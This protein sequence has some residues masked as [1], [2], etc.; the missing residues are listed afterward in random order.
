MIEYE[1]I[2]SK[3]YNQ[4]IT[5]NF[6]DHMYNYFKQ[7]YEKNDQKISL[8][9]VGPLTN[10][11]YTIQK[12]PDFCEYIEQVV[13]MGGA[14]GLGNITEYAEFN[15]WSDPMAANLVLRQQNVQIIMV[16][17]NVTH[18]VRRQEW[19]YQSL[20]QNDSFLCDQIY[21]ALRFY[22]KA[23]HR[24]DPIEHAQPPCHD[25]FTLFYLVQ[26]EGFKC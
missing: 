13:I 6:E 18:L 7:Y 26:K 21:K 14:I 17:L 25:D 22:Q 3:M 5:D 8:V 2:D 20:K 19:Y 15:I 4:I 1:P 10:I 9:S 16:P 24:Y 23:Y 12:Y 11:A